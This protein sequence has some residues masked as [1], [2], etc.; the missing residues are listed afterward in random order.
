MQIKSFNL[1]QMDTTLEN[2]LY[3]YIDRKHRGKFYKSTVCRCQWSDVGCLI[4]DKKSKSKKEHNSEKIHFELPPL[5]A[6]FA[7]WK[8]NTYS[9]FQANIFNNNRDIT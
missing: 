9:E 1:K 8:V 3:P 4:E 7:L 6:W 2:R 5:T